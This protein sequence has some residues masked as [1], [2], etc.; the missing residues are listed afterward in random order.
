[1]KKKLVLLVLSISML[2]SACG[3]SSSP[4]EQSTAPTPTPAE[5]ASRENTSSEDLEDLSTSIQAS[6]DSIVESFSPQDTAESLQDVGSYLEN[7]EVVSGEF[8]QMAGDMIGAISGIKYSDSKVEIYEFDMDSEAY[9]NTLST[10]IVHLDGFN[11][12]IPV[13]SIHNQY[14]L[15]CD[16][17]PNKDQ[18]ISVFDSLQKLHR[19]NFSK[20]INFKNN[21]T[22]LTHNSIMLTVS[23]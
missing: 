11:I 3:N 15:L 2:L 23:E 10:G 22:R 5:V 18:I 1:M 9:K 7:A 19:C 21:L 12:D 4:R 8:I 17:A 13:S 16:D 6:I 14:V 20:N